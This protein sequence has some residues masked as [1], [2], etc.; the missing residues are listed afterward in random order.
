MPKTNASQRTE[1]RVVFTR[2]TFARTLHRPD[3]KRTFLPY[4]V[5]VEVALSEIVGSSDTLVFYTYQENP[6]RAVHVV[7]S[8]MMQKWLV[9]QRGMAKGYPKPIREGR[10]RLIDD[11]EFDR[12]WVQAENSGKTVFKAG[13]PADPV[14]YYIVPTSRIIT[15]V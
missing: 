8:L 14:G 3:G 15:H 5:T 12:E 13:Q 10:A 1:P 6:E 4:R 11:L 9:G 7:T 2:G